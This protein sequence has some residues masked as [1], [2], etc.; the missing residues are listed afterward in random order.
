METIPDNRFKGFKGA[1]II[2]CAIVSTCFVMEWGLRVVGHIFFHTP[3]FDL[4]SYVFDQELKWHPNPG[5]EGPALGCE[6][7]KFNRLGFRGR[8]YSASEKNANTLRIL[9][10]GESNTAGFC[11]PD[12]ERIFTGL[13]EKKLSASLHNKIVQVANFGVVGYSTYQS[14]ILLKRY[15]DVIKPDLVVTYLGANDAIDAVSSD[16]EQITFW[17]KEMDQGINQLMTVRIIRLGARKV[18]NKLGITGEKRRVKSN[19]SASEQTLRVPPDKFLNN[20]LEIKGLAA[21]KRAKAVFLTYP[22]NH[23]IYPA[24]SE[25]MMNNYN[26]LK[27]AETK[28]G[29]YLYDFFAVIDSLPREKAFLWPKEDII[30]LTYYAHELLA[31]GL[32]EYILHIMAQPAEVNTSN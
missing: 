15:I 17:T 28:E 26:K 25:R 1:L 19:E 12:D 31:E 2:I 16:D 7:V 10:L 23:E 6:K 9:I 32:S 8:D 29:L 13:L 18:L 27:E 3:L 14:K 22:F 30:H 5:Y 24:Y 11:L 20:L 21:S 4:R